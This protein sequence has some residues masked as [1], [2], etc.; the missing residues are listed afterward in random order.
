MDEP[1]PKIGVGVLVYKDGKILM[2]KRINISGHG[3]YAG[4]GGH[5]EFGETIEECAARE[6][7]EE[8]NIEIENIK[9]IS[10]ATLLFDGST[11]HYIDIGVVAD[12]KAGEIQNL[13]PTKRED[14]AWY[15]LDAL[16]EP[17]YSMELRY[18]DA[19]KT[20]T[21]YQGTVRSDK[22]N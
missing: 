6:T 15:E 9:V 3:Q 2:G 20:G 7:K 19:L 1:K 4:P 5:L 16:P 21:V 14:W 12:W 10:L 18:I 22:V 17:L 8:A 13:E 11:R